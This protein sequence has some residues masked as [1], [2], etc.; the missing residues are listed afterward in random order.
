MASSQHRPQL[1][2]P[3]YWDE[4]GSSIFHLRHSAFSAAVP[5]FS[6]P[7]SCLPASEMAPDQRGHAS[8][9]MTAHLRKVCRQSLQ[10]AHSVMDSGPSRSPVPTFCPF[11]RAKRGSLHP[12]YQGRHS[13]SF[14]PPPRCP[15]PPPPRDLGLPHSTNQHR[16]GG[17]HLE[18]LQ[19]DL[20]QDHGFSSM[21]RTS[22]IRELLFIFSLPQQSDGHLPFFS[23]LAEPTRN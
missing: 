5:S 13:C 14:M 2:Q 16:G 10:H 20:G 8:P 17:A 1:Q 21:K 7:I 18:S 9:E 15:P 3:I 22:E 11:P 6:G 19:A 12:P 4:K 23:L